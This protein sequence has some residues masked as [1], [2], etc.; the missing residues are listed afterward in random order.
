MA[1][2]QQKHRAQGDAEE[3]RQMIM[4]VAYELFMQYGYRAVTTRQLAEA[5][6]LT[7]PALYH[8]FAEKQDLYLAVVSEEIAKIKAALERIVR[9]SEEVETGLRHIASF[10]LSRSRYDLNLMLHDVRYELSSDARLVLDEQ[11]REGFIL[12]L[13]TLFEQGI[14][15]GRLRSSEEGGLAPIQSA[16]LFMTTLS[17]F[18]RQPQKQAM[19]SESAAH[20][21]VADLV[22]RLLLHGLAAPERT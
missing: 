10:L 4:R 15:Q 21:A 19:Q 1:P 3:T 18:T 6:G 17:A 2:R 5:C 9:R 12:P 7:Q 14:R 11:F 8:H 13:A 22:V 16:Y 20:G